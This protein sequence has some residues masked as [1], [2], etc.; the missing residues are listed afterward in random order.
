[1]KVFILVYWCDVIDNLFGMVE[2]Y[3][4]YLLQVFVCVGG[5]EIEFVL[6]VDWVNV[7]ELSFKGLDSGYWVGMV[8]VIGVVVVGCGDIFQL[9]YGFE[10]VFWE[11]VEE[12]ILGVLQVVLNVVGIEVILEL[13]VNGLGGVFYCMCKVV[14]EGKG[15]FQLIFVFWFIYQEY[16]L[17]CLD[18]FV[19][20]VGVEDEVVMLWLDY[21]DLY[22]LDD[23]QLYWVYVKN[24]EFVVLVLV[25]FDLGFCW[26]FYQEYFVIV[27]E[28]FQV[29]GDEK[30]ILV[31][32]VIVVCKNSVCYCKE[33]LVI[34]GV[35]ILCGGDDF[36]WM[37]DCNGCVVGQLVNLCFKIDNEME[38]SGC[39][40]L[41][42]DWV[43]VVGYQVLVYVDI[44]GVG[45]G[46]VDCCEECGYVM[47]YKFNFGVKVL[48]FE[49]YVNKCVEIWGG[50]KEWF[51]DEVGVLIFD[52]DVLYGDICLVVWGQGVI[53][54]DL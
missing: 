36:I 37:I 14:Q 33:L 53:C 8:L 26:K 49:C 12:V 54:F 44:M 6:L 31:K 30:F 50:M 23:D 38:I 7:K 28:V 29:G 9:F 39:L 5:Y 46:V 43:L 45:G 47:V 10:V 35:D 15:E 32:G 48:E 17:F 3:Y 34:I 19:W 20:L 24:V 16:C 51:G 52:D 2:C 13:I 11:D 41:E 4:E 21:G 1:M 27:E 40:C 42:I 18:G 22:D 25:D